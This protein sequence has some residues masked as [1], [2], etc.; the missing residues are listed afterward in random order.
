MVIGRACPAQT[1]PVSSEASIAVGNRAVK[2]SRS[3]NLWTRRYAFPRFHERLNMYALADWA[4][5]FF[6]LLS[7]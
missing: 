1:V 7:S 5:R 2:L 4:S 6:S 3:T